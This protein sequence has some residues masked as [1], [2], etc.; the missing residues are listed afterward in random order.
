MYDEDKWCNQD[1]ERE[2]LKEIL[3]KYSWASEIEQSFDY[4]ESN[5]TSLEEAYNKAINASYSYG[6]SAEYEN[7]IDT[8]TFLADFSNGIESKEAKVINSF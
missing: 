2:A 1:L 5:N 7:F 3:S 8:R 4:E 6:P